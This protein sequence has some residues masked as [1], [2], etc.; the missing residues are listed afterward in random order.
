MRSNLSQL[1]SDCWLHSTYGMIAAMLR[2]FSLTLILTI[3]LAFLLTACGPG[4]LPEQVIVS[5][6]SDGDTQEL[7]LPQ[8][9]TVRDALRTASVTLAELDRVR[10]PETS[11]LTS[12]MGITV[13][14]VIQT[15]EQVTETIPYGSQTQ[16]DTTLL[17]S[18]RRILQAG[19]NGILATHYRLTYQDGQLINKVELSQEVIATP[20]PEIARV[21]LE[22]D[23][24]TVPLSGTLVYLSNNN[25][26]AVR[27]TSGNKRALTTEGDLDAHVF[28]LSSDGRWLLY[29]RGNTSTLN[30]L[31]VVDTTLATPEP[32]ELKINGVLW[33]GFA[34][35]SQ[36]IA[37]SRGEPSPGLPGWKAL[38]D[39]SILPFTTGKLGKSKEII[40]ASATT[41]YAWWG[42]TYDWSPDG[43]RLAYANT[44]AIGLISPTA[45]ITRTLPLI[46]FAAYNTRSTWAWTPTIS[47]SPDGQFLIAPIHSPSPSGESDEDSPA[48]DVAALQISGTLQPRL[49]VGAGMWAA[50][51]WLGLDPANRQI[52]FG[53]S[54][55]P[56]ASDTSRY[57][58]NIMDRDGSN[59]RL[60]FPA[61]GLPGIRGLPDFTIAPDG[62][63][64]IVA[65]QG[66]LYWI[67]LNTGLTRR[68]SADGSIS[69]PR[70]AR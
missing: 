43:K 65:Y 37:Y 69:F 13:T 50:P 27:D 1:L 23:F 31:W 44:A 22:D 53:M 4:R 35:D 11:L 54:E 30:S 7:T 56:Y 48:F 63:G 15:S 52:V 61:A 18:E 42:T 10:P 5:F 16:P 8:G 38:N 46:D 14:R 49:A 60:L 70:W 20:V 57:F 3:I 29:T 40:K 59:R 41:P 21:G 62:R 51:Q 19:R 9:S 6:T 64:L 34:P 47:W 17:P 12:G 36:S 26:Y 66:D 24:T 33:A 25:A 55:T 68:L 28:S 39:L 2:R 45:K 58:L 67:N 32:Q